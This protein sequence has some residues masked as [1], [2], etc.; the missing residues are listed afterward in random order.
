MS[1]LSREQASAVEYLDG[2]ALICSGAGA[3]KTSTIVAK[4]E[5]LLQKGSDPG[6]ILCITFTN[7]AANELKARLTKS[8]GRKSADFPWVRT[9]HSSMLQ[10][11]KAHAPA[12]GFQNPIS[13]YDGSDQLGL[14]KNILENSFDM[15]AKYSKAVRAH[16]GRAKNS[17]SPDFYIHSVKEFRKLDLIFEQYNQRLKESNAMDFDDILVH[18]FNLL[19][20]NAPVRSAY[21]DLFQYILLDEHQDSNS[22]Q[23]AIVKLLVNK[24]NITVVGDFSQSIYG[25]RGADPG[26]FARF[27]SEY[28]GTKIFLLERNF[29]S[30]AP[31]V[32]LGNEIISFNNEEIKKKCFSTRP[33][34]PASLRGFDNSYIEARWVA[35]RCRAY[36]QDALPFEQMAVLYRTSFISRIIE[37][38]FNELGVPYKLVGGVSFFERREIKDLTSYLACAVNPKDDV[39]FER[40][41]NAP[42]RGIGKKSI[43][44]IREIPLPGASLIEKSPMA[45]QKKIGLQKVA[46]GV[47]MVLFILERIKNMPPGEALKEVMEITQYERYLETWAGE[48]DDSSLSSRMDNIDELLSIAEGKESIEEFLEDCSLRSEEDSDEEE[49]RGVRLST[50]HS[51]KGLEF[52]TVFLVGCERN[53]LPHWRSVEEDAGNSKGGNVEEERRLFYVACTRAGRNL[54]IS[55][56]GMRQNKPSGISPF[57]EELSGDHLN[58]L[59]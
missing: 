46:A 48:G 24:G 58:R 56:A 36:R 10:I 30:T 21:R 45:I 13:I 8:T 35:E 16:I 33:G 47:G 38:A 18:A 59:D 17:I 7:K 22:I 19:D 43:Q 54:H 12:I 42:K 41:L 1:S 53:I 40:I 29:R 27:P 3:G 4:F 39:A 49:D 28:E 52:H 26:F 37:K 6:R 55:Y 51:A 31:I 14:V 11:L 5:Y 2:P 50:I 9:F 25:F 44:K 23:N 57:L 20:S 34:S 32:E 15:D